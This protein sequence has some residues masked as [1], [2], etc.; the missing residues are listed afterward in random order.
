MDANIRIYF[1]WYI[2]IDLAFD[3]AEDSLTLQKGVLGF[4]RCAT[5]VAHYQLNEVFDN[6]IIS[7]SKITGLLRESDP[8]TYSRRYVDDV[9][10]PKKKV[11]RWN[12]D[13]GSNEKGQ[14]AAILMF[15]IVN[16][17][18]NGLHGAWQNVLYFNIG[19]RFYSK[20][21]YS[22]FIA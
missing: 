18:G 19:C 17:H 14:V 7:L 16:E 22:Q 5:I 9:K 8:P 2:L 4:H 10:K 13:F 12:V 6:I 15:S 20:F 11:D 3:N 21:V 1:L